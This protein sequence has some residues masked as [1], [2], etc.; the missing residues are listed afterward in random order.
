MGTEYTHIKLEPKQMRM[1]RFC[2]VIKWAANEQV[3]LRRDSPMCICLR[4]SDPPDGESPLARDEWRAE[5]LQIR[6][7]HRARKSLRQAMSVTPYSVLC[8]IAERE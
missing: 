6:F 2:I 5:L 4:N 1:N 3:L 8:G 7:A